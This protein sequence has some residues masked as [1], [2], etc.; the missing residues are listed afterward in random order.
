MYTESSLAAQTTT[1]SIPDLAVSHARH[2]IKAAWSGHARA[3]NATAAQHAALAV[4][5]DIPLDKAFTP[6]TNQR[7]LANGARPHQGRD[8]A[9]SRAL[10][11][12]ASAWSP[13]VGLIAPLEPAAQRWGGAY[14]D[15]DAHPFFLPA[16]LAKAQAKAGMS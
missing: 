7:K 4:L 12:D 5:L 16:K 15:L 3:R 6:I 13:W 1:S 14:Y 10:S 2:A 11:G 9:L 8:L